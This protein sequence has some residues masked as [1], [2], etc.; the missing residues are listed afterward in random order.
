MKYKKSSTKDQ[1]YEGRNK[2]KNVIQ[3][4]LLSSNNSLK[5]SAMQNILKNGE[6]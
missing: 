3:K 4:I 1:L 2:N 5:S 6:L